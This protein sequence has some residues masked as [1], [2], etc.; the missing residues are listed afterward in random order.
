MRLEKDSMGKR[1]V[2][3][4]AYYG[5]QT[6]R[7]LANFPVSGRRE[8][9]ELVRAYAMIKFAAARTNIKLGVLDGEKGKAI[10]RAAKRVMDGDLADQFPVDVFQAGAGTSFN[11]NINEVIANVALETLGRKKGDYAFIS[12]NDHVNRGQSTNDTF[13]TASHIAAAWML[14]TLFERLIDL[15]KT[16]DRKSNDFKDVMKSGRTHLMDALP[17]TL[18][19]EFQAY[20]SAIAASRR[21]LEQ[22][23]DDLMPIPLG[24][25]AVGT[26]MNAHP[27]FASM[28]ISELARISKLPL[29]EMSDKSLGLQ[30]R[31]PL[32]GISSALRELAVELGRIANDLRLMASGP[33][34]GLGEIALPEVQPGSSIMPGKSNPVMAECLNMICYELIG[35]DLAITLASQAGQLELNVMT[36][37][38][39]H[40][41]LD[42]LSLLN[43]YLPSFGE[44]CLRGIIANEERCSMW[45]NRNPILITHLAPRIGYLK[46]AEIAKEAMSSG[47]DIIDLIVDEKIM[48]RKEAEKVLD[49]TEMLGLGLDRRKST[50]GRKK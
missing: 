49:P 9:P 40:K 36:P 30:S 44:R 50:K 35:N 21:R 48:S 18:G 5:V 43:N 6:M 34:T 31:S 7:A 23:Y 22:R 39:T 17:V 14:G 28:A 12:P 41:V 27:E 29:T 10:E 47:R 2:P 16:L 19:G 33:T 20:A 26:G 11:M 37:L 25:T 3:D 13:P 42:S 15:E 45:L 4:D 1:G 46:A 32:L 24:G 8:R 38:I